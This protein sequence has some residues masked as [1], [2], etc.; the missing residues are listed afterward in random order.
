MLG[1]IAQIGITSED[2]NDILGVSLSVGSGNGSRTAAKEQRQDEEDCFRRTVA[3][4][5]RPE[6]SPIKDNFKAIAVELRAQLQDVFALNRHKCSQGLFA[7]DDPLSPR[8]QE[9]YPQQALY[10]PIS[11][12]GKE[13]LARDEHLL[14]SEMAQAVRGFLGYYYHN[15]DDYDQIRFPIFYETDVGEADVVEVIRISP[16]D[17][18]SLINEREELKKSREAG[19]KA[20]RKLAGVS[21]HHFGAFLDQTWRQNDIMWG[22]LDGAERLISALLPGEQNALVRQELINEAHTAILKEELKPQSLLALKS[23]MSEAL[24]RAS[25][26]LSVN[27][28]IGKALE[29]LESSV[30]KTRLEEIMRLSLTDDELLD[31]MKKGYEVNRQLDPKPMLNSMSR[32]TQIIGKMFENIADAN[33]LDGKQLAWIA[34]LGQVFWGLVTVAVPHSIA[35]LLIFHWLKLLYLFGALVILGS[36]L[37]GQPEVQRFGWTALVATAAINVC[38]LLLGDYMRDR[39]SLVTR[40]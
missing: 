27:E 3:M 5:Q 34:R 7:L 25:T 21:L 17:A 8:H 19:K 1:L 22:R 33:A 31:F 14:A 29:P 30:V 9:L 12:R 4:L 24:L 39:T 28:A 2:L 23:T 10:E 15:F 13:L 6:K 26:G 38:V 20:R 32:A 18:T 11:P 37:L 36:I 16:E 40:L 35:N